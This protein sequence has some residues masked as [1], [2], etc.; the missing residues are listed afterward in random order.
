MFHLSRKS[1]LF[2][3]ICF[4]TACSHPPATALPTIKP[5]PTHRPLPTLS[6]DCAA[7]SHV[8]QL[9]SG[10][11]VR[12]YRLYVPRSYQRGKPAALIFGFH[13][14]TGHAGE[15]EAYS[16][17]SPLAERAGF[18]VVY[19]Q[20]SGEQY[21]TWETQAGS[22]DVQFVRDLIDHL[23]SICSIDPARIYATGHSLGGGMAHRLACD[24]ADRIAAIGPVSGAYQNPLPCAP[25]QPVAV[26]SVH[27][28]SDTIVFYQGIPPKGMLI[29]NYTAIG[30]PIPQWASAWAGRN[31]CDTKSTITLNQDPVS[32]QQWSNC[33]NT[34]EVVLYTI[35]DGEHGWPG[36]MDAAQT[37]W[38][39]FAKHPHLAG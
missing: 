38:D 8:N 6:A 34:A 35:N 13:G 27:G 11:E 22:K 18:I 26:V 9:V 14:N 30:T 23:Q 12:Q 28:T 25:T 31:G 10:A 3:L 37:I 17:F 4:L 29:E 2:V 39:F 36:E 16:G 5:F 24:L 32:A 33:R 1:A 20:G 7:G 15:F 21:P 19:P